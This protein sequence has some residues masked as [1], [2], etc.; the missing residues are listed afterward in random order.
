MNNKAIAQDYLVKIVAGQIDEAF[1]QHVGPDFKHHNPYSA[2]QAADLVAGMKEA[3]AQFPRKN[4]E[5]KR[6]L[7][8]GDLVAIHSRLQMEPNQ[9][10]MA[11]VH[12]MRFSNDRIVELWDIGQVAPE[13]NPNRN[14]LF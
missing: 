6:I 3:H 5:I 7:E 11:V 12:I 2:G 9:P 1:A 13:K 14:G 10:E 8:D 4:F